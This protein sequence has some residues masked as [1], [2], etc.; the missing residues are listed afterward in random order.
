MK[1][2]SPWISRILALALFTGTAAW[3]GL[4]GAPDRAAQQNTPQ[5]P[6]PLVSTQVVTTQTHAQPLMLT[7]FTRAKAEDVLTFDSGGL[8]SKVLVEKGQTVAKGD[9][10]AELDSSVEK[11]QMSQAESQLNLA[12]DRVARLEKLASSGSATQT[13]LDEARTSLIQAQAQMV[14]ATDTYQSRFLHAPFQGTIN[15]ILIEEGVRVNAGGQALHIVDRSQVFVDAYLSQDEYQALDKN[16]PAQIN[17]THTAHLSFLSDI[18]NENRTFR[19]EFLLDEEATLSLNTRVDVQ[20]TSKPMEASEIDLNTIVIDSSGQTGVMI[21]NNKK[22]S[23][24]PVRVLSSQKTTWVSG[25]TGTQTLIVAGQ[26]TIKD[27]Q[28]VRTE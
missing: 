19:A 2:Q 21:M 13:S 5:A 6:A 25:L 8:V 28:T 10:L 3:V 7:G 9:L 11:A 14:S 26:N 22:A 4:G 17:N 12:Q 20:A 23:F 1:H 15:D 27:G 18:G 16:Q 24:K